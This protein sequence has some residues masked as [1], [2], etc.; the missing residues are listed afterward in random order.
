MFCTF[1]LYWPLF[2][3]LIIAALAATALNFHTGSNWMHY[4]MGFFLCQFA[5]LK[6]F[7]PVDFA[8]GFQMY[9]FI[10]SKIRV[11][12]LIYPFIELALGLC[13]LGFI[14]PTATYWATAAVFGVGTIGVISALSQ[15][16]NLKCACM[17]TI[18]NVPLST[19]TLTEDLL[20]VIM[21][22]VLVSK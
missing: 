9:D 4:F 17:G 20:M 11:Y 22:L 16:L 13:Y 2:A 5:M 8:N 12:A 14:Q 7:H 15:G 10:G 19:V 18:L 21:S 1:L 3:L 6:L